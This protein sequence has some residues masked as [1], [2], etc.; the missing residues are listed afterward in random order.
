MLDAIPLARGTKGAHIINPLMMGR[1]KKNAEKGI[2]LRTYILTLVTF[3][4]NKRSR[5]AVLRTKAI[6]RVPSSWPIINCCPVVIY[7][8]GNSNG[9]RCRVTEAIADFE[10]DRIHTSVQRSVAF[11]PQ[12]D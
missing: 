3:P 5:S 7:W 9:H 2:A 11:R 8:H 12:L 4:E 6:Y 1:P 10:R